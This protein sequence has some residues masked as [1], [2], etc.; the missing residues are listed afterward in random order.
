MTGKKRYRVKGDT[1]RDLR[2]LR[3]MGPEDL[4]KESGVSESTIRRMEAGGVRSHRGNIRKIAKALGV[5]AGD[6]IEFDDPELHR[7]LRSL[8]LA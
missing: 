3:F 6:I 4:S 5:E 1:V 8:V 7:R 2:E